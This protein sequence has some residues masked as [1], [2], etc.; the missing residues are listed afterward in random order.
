MRFD[1]LD[2]KY[3]EEQV[4]RVATA[5]ARIREGDQ[6]ADGRVVPEAEDLVIGAGRRMRMAVLFLDISGFS[7]LPSETVE[8]QDLLMRALNLFFT[9][10]VRIAEDYGGTVEK[11]T[12]DGLMAYFP[13]EA[14]PSGVGATRALAASLTMRAAN[15]YLVGPTF[16]ASGLKPFEFRICIDAGQ[17]TVARL[18]AAK[19]YNSVAAIGATANRACKFLKL[20]SGSDTILGDQARND[21]PSHWRLLFTEPLGKPSGWIYRVSK[22]EYPVWRFSAHW[23]KLV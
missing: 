18:G 15:E 20:A 21:I 11:N 2:A 22:E 12:G 8:E 14:D 5:S 16:Q 17:V 23:T 3:W 10:M 4:T 6:P 1:G 7:D 9:E 19:R 13:D